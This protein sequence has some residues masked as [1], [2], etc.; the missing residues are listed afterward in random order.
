MDTLMAADATDAKADAYEFLQGL[1]QLILQ[2]SPRWYEMDAGIM[3]IVSGAKAN[4]RQKHLRLPESA[5]LNSFVLP[6]LHQ[7][8]QQYSSLTAEQ[9][10]AALLNEYHHTMP[11]LSCRSPIRAKKH[12]FKKTLGTSAEAIY[13][14]WTDPTRNCGLTQSCPDFAL[15]KPFAHSMVFEGKYFRK[16]SAEYAAKQLVTDIYQAFFYRGLPRVESTKQGHPE[17]DYDYGCL[18][19]Y[20]A[21]PG[22]TLANAWDNLPS[23]VKKSFWDGANIYVM[24]L[25][26]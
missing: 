22:G 12:P 6:A 4:D 23:N 19:A 13:R 9:A 2:R 20:D 3:R 26:S 25:R 11:D 8:L 14:E 17:W 10:K 21:S 16:G 15:T 24:I 1:G 18:L 5:F 7:H